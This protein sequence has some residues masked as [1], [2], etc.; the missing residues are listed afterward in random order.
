[1]KRVVLSLSALMV[2]LLTALAFTVVPASAQQAAAPP[3]LD[4]VPVSGTTEDGSTFTGTVVPT[5]FTSQGRQLL[6][7]GTLTGTMRDASGA[8]T[9]TVSDTPVSLP[10][11]LP[12]GICPIL[13]LTLGP[14]DLNLLGLK[15]HLDRVVLDITAISGPGNLLGNLLCAIAGILDGTGDLALLPGLLAQ[16]NALLGLGR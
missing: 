16:L 10:V 5:A 2:A 3:P 11:A 13:H 7:N 9:G 8:T 1:M 12:S 15:V 4:S 14:L 6:L